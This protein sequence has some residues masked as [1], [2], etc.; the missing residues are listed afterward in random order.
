MMLQDDQ[1]DKKKTEIKTKNQPD[2]KKTEN[3]TKTVRRRA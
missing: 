2:K 3:K 1:P